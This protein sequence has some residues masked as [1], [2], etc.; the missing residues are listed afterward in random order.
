MLSVAQIET[1]LNDMIPFR[2]AAHNTSS[3]VQFYSIKKFEDTSYR[4]NRSLRFYQKYSPGGGNSDG[5][6]IRIATKE[7][8]KRSE[9]NRILIVLSDGLPSSTNGRK[10]SP[11]D[12]TKAAIREARKAG[13]EV[14]GIF[15]G[16][17]EFRRK[18]AK[19]YEYMY[20]YNI[21]NMALGDIQR[22]LAKVVGNIIKR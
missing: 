6:A 13:I 2:V 12:D 10:C 15:F 5:D 21:L 18:T 22:S 4:K 16:S 9:K 7:L 1:A 17:A 3:N 11:E 19:Q 20:E 14:I 8:K